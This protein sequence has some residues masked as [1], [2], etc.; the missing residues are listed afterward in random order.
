MC[1]EVNVT[2]VCNNNGHWKLISE[3]SSCLE[4]NYFGMFLHNATPYYYAYHI[5]HEQVGI[6]ITASI[7]VDNPRPTQDAKIVVVSSVTSFVLGSL[8]FFFVGLMCGYLCRRRKILADT[9]LSTRNVVPLYDD[10]HGQL[11]RQN[12]EIFETKEN[13]AYGPVINQESC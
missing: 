3:D 5:L 8:S 7:H 6:A 1:T 13:V 4:V 10:V 12:E 9:A 11:P 2:A